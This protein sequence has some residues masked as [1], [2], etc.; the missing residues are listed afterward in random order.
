MSSS[1]SSIY[2]ILAKLNKVTQGCTAAG[3]TRPIS[4]FSCFYRTWLTSWIKT[5]CM[6]KWLQTHMLSQVCIGQGSEAQ[7]TAGLLLN[8][9]SEKGFGATLDYSKCYD[10]MDPLGTLALMQ[11]AGLPAFCR[12]VWTSQVRHVE[13]PAVLIRAHTAT[14][15]GCPLG[16]LALSLW[17][18][19]P[20]AAD[21]VTQTYLDD[22][23]FSASTA[24]GRPSLSGFRLGG[25]S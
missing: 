13:W 6:R 8:S 12:A 18:V 3:D 23:S 17:M 15:Q 20:V 19:Q 25:F 2:L 1:S 5:P 24:G 14:S 22:R 10:S 16:P 9:I 4:I 21:G 11:L 7:L